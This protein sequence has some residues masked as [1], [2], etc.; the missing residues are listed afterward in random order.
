MLLPRISA[1]LCIFVKPFDEEV[2]R[3]LYVF[4]R[5]IQD[6]EKELKINIELTC[7][8]NLNQAFAENDAL[9]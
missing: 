8:E 1:R 2:F 6:L 9:L 5:F 4:V 7:H 3:S